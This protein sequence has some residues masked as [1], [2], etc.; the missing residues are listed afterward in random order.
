MLI[1][2]NIWFY[3]WLFYLSA[4][5]LFDLLYLHNILLTFRIYCL[6]HSYFL[7]CNFCL[8]YFIFYCL[9]YFL[10]KYFAL[11]FLFRNLW[12]LLFELI[13]YRILIF[14]F[15][16]L[17]LCYRYYCLL[18]LIFLYFFRWYIIFQFSIKF[19]RFRWCWFLFGH[20]LKYFITLLFWQLDLFTLCGFRLFDD[21]FF[22]IKFSRWF[23]LLNYY[24]LCYHIIDWC[25][26]KIICIFL[27][28][29]LK[30]LNRFNDAGSLLMVSL[31]LLLLTDRT[32]I[33]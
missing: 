22:W 7:F 2:R 3:N 26:W 11:F 27:L 29:F 23:Y 18:F 24:I 25:G 21:N 32:N 31:I 6:L 28:I 5:S 4:F 14:F 16:L 30:L 9:Y 17:F 13:L 12:L 15:Y 1:L 10:I 20:S 19:W 8:Y 33:P